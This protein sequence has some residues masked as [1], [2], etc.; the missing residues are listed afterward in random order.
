LIYLEQTEK[1]FLLNIEIYFK[2]NSREPIEEHRHETQW[3]SVH[4]LGRDK[5]PQIFSQNKPL[6]KIFFPIIQ[7]SHI[8]K[9]IKTILKIN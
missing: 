7:F 8:Y 1:L 3:S 2:P 4:T 9:P 6:F 5:I